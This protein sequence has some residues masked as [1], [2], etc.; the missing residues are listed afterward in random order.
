M[1]MRV[2]ESI[3]WKWVFEWKRDLEML[4]ESMTCLNR[5]TSSREGEEHWSWIHSSKGVY[6]TSEAY[7]R[8]AS[9]EHTE[10]QQVD[11]KIFKI[12]GIIMLQRGLML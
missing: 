7:K 6:V 4:N 5:Y 11:T 3:T 1:E 12:C 9:D 10:T 8:A 2:W